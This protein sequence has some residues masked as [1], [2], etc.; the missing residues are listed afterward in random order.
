MTP[1]PAP[2]SVLI[3]DPYPDCA[4]SLAGV[5]AYHG[6]KVRI[7]YTPADA[8][9][10]VADDPPDVVISEARFNDMDGFTLVQRIMGLASESVVFV[11]VTG[12]H[13]FRG[14]A[15]LCGF[16]HFLVKPADPDELVRLLDGIGCAAPEPLV[17]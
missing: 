8:L 7:A 14:R 16:D 3:V 15:T 6:H 1:L 4:D 10:L 13:E 11:M 5:L 9:Q 12:R 17:V 2:C